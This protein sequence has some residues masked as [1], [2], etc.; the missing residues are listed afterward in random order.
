MFNHLNV[1]MIAV[2]IVVDALV[3]QQHVLLRS[4]RVPLAIL[5]GSL[6][7]NLSERALWGSSTSIGIRRIRI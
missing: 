5:R 2:V 6:E 3:V 7:V 4:F 1:A